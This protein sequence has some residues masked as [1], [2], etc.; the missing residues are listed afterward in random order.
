MRTFPRSD[1]SETWQGRSP[2][3]PQHANINVSHNV[4]PKPRSDR[5]HREHLGSGSHTVHTL[6]YEQLEPF[7]RPVSPEN[8][9]G[10]N[11]QPPQ[12]SHLR[13]SREGES[14]SSYGRAHMDYLSS[15]KPHLARVGNE[16]RMGD[17][18]SSAQPETLQDRSTHH[19]RHSHQADWQGVAASPRS[20]PTRT[21][22]HPVSENVDERKNIFVSQKQRSH[23]S[24]GTE[25]TGHRR[26]SG[27]DKN[28]FENFGE[29]QSARSP[30]RTRR[31]TGRSSVRDDSNRIALE[32]R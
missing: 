21:R 4:L 24:F 1:S 7:P 30:T 28:P 23:E 17:V 9:Q 15:Q 25:E 32:Q 22:S 11:P 2:Q 3:P 19:L 16:H 8:W 20:A 27:S 14:T 31:G 12:H 13:L 29:A 5:A 10:E 18:N 6:G 26:F